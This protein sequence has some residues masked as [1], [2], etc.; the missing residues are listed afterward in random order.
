MAGQASAQCKGW[1]DA[2]HQSH[3]ER[4]GPR[5]CST[6]EDDRIPDREWPLRV[7][8]PHRLRLRRPHSEL[9]HAM[10]LPWQSFATFAATRDECLLSVLTKRS[11]GW[12]ASGRG[13]PFEEQHPLFFDT[14]HARRDDRNGELP[15][16]GCDVWPLKQASD[17]I[18]TG[19]ARTLGGKP[20]SSLSVAVTV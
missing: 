13:F 12:D 10:Q 4:R 8:D 17:V 14:E 1:S 11:Y 3:I 15:V 7:A 20:A 5:S 6:G 18:V 2:W 19:H 9:R 16:H